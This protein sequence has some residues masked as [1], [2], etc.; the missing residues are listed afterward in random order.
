MMDPLDFFGST[1]P[2]KD[3]QEIKERVESFIEYHKADGKKVALITSGGTL[4]PLEQQTVRH[5]D[6]FSTGTRGSTSA[7]QFL[8]RG[9]AVIF[10]YRDSSFFP[11]TRLLLSNKE[12]LFDWL[13]CD[14]DGHISLNPP[15]NLKDTVVTSLTKYNEVKS[16]NRLLSIS[17]VSVFDY[18]H[19]LRLLSQLM[20]TLNKHAFIYLAAAVSD[21]YIHPK[22]MVSQVFIH[23]FSCQIFP[24]FFS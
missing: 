5:L 4:V 16:S 10:L 22:D 8:L 19:Y 1:E 12:T 9:Y 23:R 11:Y 3:L 18:L 20:K 7:E 14:S 15:S 13:N 17:F 2:P 21:F 24:V 6:N